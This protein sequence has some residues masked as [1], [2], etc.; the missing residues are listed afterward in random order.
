MPKVKQSTNKKT[1]SGELTVR[2]VRPHK[3]FPEA[4]FKGQ[5]LLYCTAEGIFHRLIH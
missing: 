4:I 5:S 3:K 1:F 2:H